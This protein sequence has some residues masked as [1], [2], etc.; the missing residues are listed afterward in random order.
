MC[1]TYLYLRS[2]RENFQKM[3]KENSDLRTQLNSAVDFSK[4]L[5]TQEEKLLKE[6]QL[7]TE[8]ANLGS[9]LAGRVENLKRNMKVVVFMVEPL[10]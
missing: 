8:E 2:L 7:R 4:Q 9:K 1:V 3:T 10:F 5:I 6:L